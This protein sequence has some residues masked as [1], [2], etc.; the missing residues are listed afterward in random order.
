[1]NT[2]T[3]DGVEMVVVQV[4][5]LNNLRTAVN[6]ILDTE[7]FTMRVASLPFDVYE[8][9]L[10]D[11][12]HNRRMLER[13]AV[14]EEALEAHIRAQNE[15][16]E[17]HYQPGDQVQDD[18]GSTVTILEFDE[19]DFTHLGLPYLGQYESGETRWFSEDELSPI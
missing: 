7:S 18:A 10:R 17:F 14:S 5:G 2:I 12:P 19:N 15:G 16:Q 1:M 4:I 8:I 6:T 11:E 13:F 9:A 3:Q